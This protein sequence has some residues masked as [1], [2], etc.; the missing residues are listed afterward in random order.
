MWSVVNAGADRAP[1]LIAN[2]AVLIIAD[3]EPLGCL[4]PFMFPCVKELV[5]VTYRSSGVLSGSTFSQVPCSVLP[6]TRVLTGGSPA[7]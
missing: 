7:G 5:G 3:T 4:F 6:T 2:T 1:L